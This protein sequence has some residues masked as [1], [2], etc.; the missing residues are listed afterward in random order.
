MRFLLLA[1]DYDGTLATDG[2]VDTPTL[3]ALDR[4]RASGRKLILV[5]GRHLQDLQNV[6][7]RLELFDRVVAEN[8]ALLYRPATREEKL[9]CEGSHQEFVSLLRDR[10]VPVEVG[11]CIVSTWQPHDVEVLKAI[12][13]LGLDLQVIFNKGAV[14]VLP[15]GV[16]KA[17]GLKA[18]LGELGL[19]PHN[20]VSVGDAE[21]DHSF[22][23]ISECAVAVANALPALKDRA[24]VVL[25]QPRGAGVTEL[26]DR[27][28][29]DDLAE[30]DSGLQRHSISLGRRAGDS[31][32]QVLF[33]PRGGSILVAGPS[34]SGKSTAVAGILEQ[35]LEHEYQFCLL[36]PEGDYDDFSGALSFGTSKEPP[37]TKAILR[38][39]ESPE[40]SVIVN[41]LGVPLDDRPGFF[42]SL[43]SSL[44]ELRLRSGRP[45][46]LVIDE[47]HHLLPSSWSPMMPTVS[48]VLESAI[49]I[50]VHPEHVA[51]AALD[52]VNA[53]IAIGSEA[54][55]TIGAFSDAVEA[56]PPHGENAALET[57]EAMVW[58]RTSV[59]PPVRVKTVRSTKERRRHV[60]L[61]AEGELSE[62]QSFYFC[63][64]E[65]KLNL[66]AQNLKTFVQIAEGVDDATWM[67]HL[68]KGDYSGWFKAVIKDDEL[69]ALAA[70]VERDPAASPEESRQKIVE[71]IG[72]RYT[73]PA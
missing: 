2:T 8:G 7:P 27:L 52:H 62:Q 56:A 60:R 32:A 58:L 29:A 33:S 67:H 15:S 50:T 35:L 22:L 13:D 51:R 24:D 19:S 63:G 14:M 16:N 12:K 37:D 44:Q 57:G 45:H 40:E 25:Q 41:L 38:A 59:E 43:L 54:L 11:R 42:G 21:N 46:W 30:F 39:L 53:V 36:D 10:N 64:P 66:R 4:L 61:Y 68:Q 31:S 5:T 18:A 26:V 20:V 6:F 47:A 3:A 73:A 69:S 65:S 71:A 34:A 28:I 23:R 17:S 55:K 48:H 1:T 70:G 49:L 72:S 9:L